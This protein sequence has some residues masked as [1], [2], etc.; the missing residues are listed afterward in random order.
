L[1]GGNRP[2]IKLTAPKGAKRVVSGVDIDPGTVPSSTIFT[3]KMKQKE[4]ARTVGS[5]HSRSSTSTGTVKQPSVDV[6]D[7]DDDDLLIEG[8]PT[9][10]IKVS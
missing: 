1:E 9:E 6:D 7:E 5:T 4:P 10:R 3:K 2:A 8:A